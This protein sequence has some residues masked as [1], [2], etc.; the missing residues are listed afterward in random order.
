MKKITFLL[1]LCASS[2]FYA[3]STKKV[4][5]QQWKVNLLVPGVEYEFGVGDQSTLSLGLG[6]A[7]A[8]AGGSDRRTEFGLFPFAE[9]KYRNYINFERRERKGKH[10]YG[11]SGNFVGGGILVYDGNPLLGNLEFVT[12]NGIQASAFYGLQ[13][14]YKKGFNFTLEFGLV[15]FNTDFDDGVSPWANFSIGWVLG[16]KR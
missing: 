5:N 6:T 2:F 11:N 10:T 1:C 15:Y 14:T 16:K 3:Q 12:D 9:G 4:E 7:V 13:R 8:V